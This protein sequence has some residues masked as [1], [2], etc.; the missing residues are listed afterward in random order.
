MY[1]YNIYSDHELIT[2]LKGDDHAA[3]TEI[4]KRYW[5][6][7]L[8]IAWNHSH[9]KATSKDI[10]HDVFMSLWDRRNTVEILNLSAF[11]ATSVKFSIFKF[12]Q[13]ESRRTELINRNYQFEELTNDEDKLDALFLNEYINGIVEEMP[14]KCR[15]VFSL[16][17]DLG[18]KNAEIADK[19]NITEKG[20]EA[21]LTRALKII[22]AELKKNIWLLLLFPA[23]ILYYIFK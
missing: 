6:K 21:N 11:L 4:Y 22:R 20:V 10:V 12:Y 2:L 5:K 23:C 3:F 18:M 8:L 15:L 1:N 16:S 9:D 7:M 19:L 17:R 14:E 13:K